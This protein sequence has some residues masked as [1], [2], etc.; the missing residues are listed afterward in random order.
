MDTEAAYTLIENAISAGRPA[1][2]YLIV[3]DVRGAALELAER[4]LE[5]LFG[6]EHVKDR[7][8]P[9]I[10]WLAPELKSR[11]ISVESMH[12]RLVD[13]MAQTAFAGGWKAGVVVAAEC[14]N[15]TSAN[16][17]LKTL[18][19]PTP[20]TIFLLLTDSPE[21]LLPTIVSRC[22]RIDLVQPGGHRLSEP[23]LSRLL[24][25]LSDPALSGVTAKAATA[26]RIAG[27]LAELKEK[28]EELV[29]EETATEDEGPGEET[30][31]D[32]F[33]AL[34]ESRYREF[35]TG[36]ARELSGWFRDLAA[37][38]AAGAD[39]PLV[40]PDYRAILEARAA[41]LTRAQAFRN[42]EAVEELVRALGRNMKEDMALFAFTDA[43]QFGAEGK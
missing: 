20:Q 26:M 19:E 13:P 16:A 9:D 29:D 22:Q 11:V 4:V 2:G 38:R 39:V 31:K 5:R 21:R 34:V 10:H 30:T 41:H 33:K 27:L 25:I 40:N 42:V 7:A 18:E 6:A 3:G 24:T 35:R 32:Q 15:P 8:H 36:V 17:F 28:A 14:L 43:V 1:H 37:I 12:E 23:W